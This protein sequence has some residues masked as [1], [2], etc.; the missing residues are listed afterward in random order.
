MSAK[1]ATREELLAQISAWNARYPV[2]TEVHTQLYPD[3]VYKTRTQAVL[4]LDQ[5]VVVYLEALNGYF[6][7]H[8]VHPIERNDSRNEHAHDGPTKRIAVLFPGQGAQSKGMGKNLFREFPLLTRRSDEILGYSIERLCLENPENQLNLT[9]YTQVALYVVNALDYM[10]RRQQ[11]DPSVMAE[12]LM[13]HS[14]GE[15][16]ALL[17]GGAFDFETGLRLVMKR[18]ELMGATAGGA[19]AAVLGESPDRLRQ[20]L[21][22]HG[23]DVIELANYNTPKQTVI[24][25]PS[26]AIARAM[27]L[28]SAEKIM[29]IPL[30]VS[31]AFHSRSMQAAQQ[32]FAEF[33]KTF[34]FNAPNPPVIANATARPYEQGRIT[35]TLIDQITSP[36]RWTES[37]RYVLRQGQFEFT[38]IGSSILTKMV[39]EIASTAIPDVASHAA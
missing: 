30:N 35:E 26:E 39:K 25:G 5:K 37:I 6:D 29:A 21:D 32:S 38:E 28:L 16:N 15:Y 3:R 14:L 9:Q 20:A 12:F 19:M 11:N 13:G 36:V 22:Q 34:S 31:A 24:S 1:R 4:F 23:L 8:E 7:L 10:A 33:V 18:G 17:A 27:H 2:G